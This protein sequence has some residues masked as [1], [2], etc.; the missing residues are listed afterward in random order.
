MA[1]NM[2]GSLTDATKAK[3]R[4]AAKAKNKVVVDENKMSSL[5]QWLNRIRKSKLDE[6]NWPKHCVVPTTTPPLV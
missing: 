3:A 6:H 1:P 2:R 4:A 5:H